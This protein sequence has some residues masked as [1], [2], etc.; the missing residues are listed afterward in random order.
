[1]IMLS[2]GSLNAGFWSLLLVS[3]CV[4]LSLLNAQVRF[5]SIYSELRIFPFFL[6]F[7]FIAR[8][9]STPGEIFIEV[10]GITASWQGAWLGLQVCWR[11]SLIVLVSLGFI[12]ST[13]TSEIK[14]AVEYYFAKIPM[15]PEKRISTML[16]LMV[17]F[18]PLILSQVQETMDAQKARCVE[19][20]KNP[21]T[22]LVKLTIPVIRRVF[23]NGDQ[24]AIAM[25]SRCYT[26]D[27]TSP[28]LVSSPLDW[29][30]LTG[31]SL[32]VIIMQM[33]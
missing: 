25:A 14:A 33:M 15:A 28:Q 29:V 9:L 20:R 5:S 2:L 11:L 13:T 18:I 21:V 32:L 23:Q 6:L 27:R 31:L 16:S 12:I 4:V 22:R 7:I 26:E 17:R 1:M 3:C 8:S 10:Y 24:L 19:R 30:F